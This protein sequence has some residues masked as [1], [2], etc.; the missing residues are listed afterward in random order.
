[1]QEF[2]EGRTQ[3]G[4]YALDLQVLTSGD[5][6]NPDEIKPTRQAV[7][8]AFRQHLGR[9]V[10][11]DVALFYYSGHGSQEKAPP[12]FWHLEPDHLDETLVLYDS[13]VAGAGTW[14][15]R[16]CRS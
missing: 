8:D 12:E 9:A 11:G 16:S 4:E 13:R 1:M 14:R 6:F 10:E 5:F 3:G 2:L 15:T 7:I